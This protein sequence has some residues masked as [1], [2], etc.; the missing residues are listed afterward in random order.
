MNEEAPTNSVS[1]GDVAGLGGSTG[2]PGFK[3]PA[4]NKYKKDNMK[5]APGP[6][7]LTRRKSFKEYITK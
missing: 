7:Q 2:E 6:L 1:G 3:K 4:I 5:N